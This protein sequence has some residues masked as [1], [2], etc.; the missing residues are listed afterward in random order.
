M[1]KNFIHY[2]FYQLL[3]FLLPIVLNAYSARALGVTNIGL[4]NLSG[5]FIAYFSLFLKLGIDMY[6]SREI[7]YAA[8]DIVEVRAVFSKIFSMQLIMGVIVIT[9]FL[10]A[11]KFVTT[12]FHLPAMLLLIQGGSLIGTLFDISWLVIGLEKFNVIIFRNLIIKILSLILVVLFIK[13]E[14]QILLYAGIVAGTNLL[15][16]LSMW[17]MLRKYIRITFDLRFVTTLKPILVLFVPIIAT[18]LFTQMDTILVGH[19]SNTRNL[20]FYTTG[21][22]LVAIPKL[23]VS[24]FGSVV[25]P[26]VAKNDVVDNDL[27]FQSMKYWLIFS[28]YVLVFIIFNSADIIFIVYGREFSDGTSQVLRIMGSILPFYVI[29]N[30]LRTQVLIPKGDDKPYVVSILIAA[31]LNVVSNIIFVPLYG[32]VGGAIAVFATEFTIFLIELIYT[33]KLSVWSKLKVLV[34]PFAVF[35]VTATIFESIWHYFISAGTYSYVVK[36]ALLLSQALVLL[37]MLSIAMPKIARE[38]LALLR[39]R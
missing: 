9:V 39:K 23:F 22:A 20:A 21:L 25:M 12:T 30:V 29:G 17:P 16:T 31:L 2:T 6:G 28:M 38:S 32:A 8:G 35:I 27:L 5:A 24:S 13:N 37:G 15:A 26:S 4:Y 1:R 10:A 3:T 14:S 19:F 18:S 33:I 36:L 7:A 34:K 11:N